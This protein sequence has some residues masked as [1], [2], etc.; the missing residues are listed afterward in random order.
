MTGGIGAGKSAVAARLAWHG[1]TVVDADQLA[2]RVVEPGTDGF[3]E[4]VRVFGRGVLRGDGSLDRPALG[5]LVFG[6][7]A[8]RE[9]LEHIIHPLVIAKM[10]ERAAAAPP[11]SVVVND[12][13]L[14]VEAGLAERFDVVI[15]VLASENV[16]VHRLTTTRAMTEREALLR[17]RAQ[18][19]DERRRAVADI[20]IENDGTLAELMGR[21]DHVWP[22]LV[23]LCR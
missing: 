4:I 9:R 8:A 16:R 2:R 20:V 22:T 15:V 17:M 3:A 6:D 21:V 14:L 1:A 23:A 10:A 7:P 11:G 5:R 13:P 18:A 12:V 19:T